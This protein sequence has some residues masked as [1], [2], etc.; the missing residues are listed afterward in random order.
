MLVEL[1]PDELF[2]AE[3]RATRNEVMRWLGSM[4]AAPPG[5]R[6]RRYARGRSR[7]EFRRLEYL[8]SGL[9]KRTV[10]GR[11]RRVSPTAAG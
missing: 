5:I 4:V 9:H 10:A 11:R 1:I 2:T 7:F 6:W 3:E 8:V